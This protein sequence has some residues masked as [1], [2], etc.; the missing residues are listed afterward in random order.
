MHKPPGTDALS[1]RGGVAAI[2]L[3][4]ILP[5]FVFLFVLA[6]DFGRVFYVE[7]IVTSAARCGAQYGSTN[8]TCALDAAGIQAKTLAEATDLDPTQLQV[9]SATGTDSAGNPYVDVTVTYPFK[10]VTSY[11]IT[12]S[13]TVA[14][15]IR[16]SVGPVLP[17]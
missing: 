4:V 9:T 10:T 7:F 1:P 14:A 2:E 11:L 17:N 13:F 3:A 15:R 16:M 6:V 12:T 8:P 5:L